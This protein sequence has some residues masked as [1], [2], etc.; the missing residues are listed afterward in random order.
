MAAGALQD[1]VG[2]G[3]LGLDVRW[4]DAPA[5]APPAPGVVRV[6][7]RRPGD[8]ASTDPDAFDILL[9]EGADGAAPWVFAPRLDEAVEAV[10]T[11]VGRQPV[12]A[13]A[14]CQ[15]LRASLKVSF[16]EA[17]A[18]E[19]LAYSMLLASEGFA[20]W[21]AAN[22][23]RTRDEA[24]G[25]RVRFEETD[26]DVRIRLTRPAARNAVDARMRD[27]LVKALAFAGDVSRT[28]GIE[29]TGEGPSFCAGGDL[30]EFGRADDPGRAHAIRTLRSATGLVRRLAGRVTARVQGACIGAGIEMPAA[31]GWLVAAP[32]AVFRLPEVGMGLVPGAGGLASIPRR[33]GRHRT[34]WWAITGA[35]LDAATALDWGLVDAVAP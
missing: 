23:P 31:A 15:V 9:A 3:G 5:A 35:D 17:L 4:T 26:G 12:A 22:P 27:E 21:R 28:G 1:I 10:R 25:P 32:D 30:D 8:P 7:L 11:A 29:L 14:A 18:L 20:A 16:D 13:A 2:A 34:A 24:P 33:I 19:S 6:G